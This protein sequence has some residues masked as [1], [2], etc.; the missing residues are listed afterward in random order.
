[1][2]V[3]SLLSLH[4]LWAT[5]VF[6][7]L[8]ETITAVTDFIVKEMNGEPKLHSFFSSDKDKF[9]NKKSL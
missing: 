8:F 3:L 4:I 9:G 1:M 5:I 6:K 7:D 2:T